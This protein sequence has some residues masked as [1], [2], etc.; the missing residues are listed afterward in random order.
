MK[1]VTGQK[2]KPPLSSLAKESRLFVC[3]TA[4][5]SKTSQCKSLKSC[6]DA[7]IQRKAAASNKICPVCKKEL[8]KKPNR[9][10]FQAVSVIYSTWWWEWIA[11]NSLDPSW[12]NNR[13]WGRQWT[14]GDREWDISRDGKYDG[15]C[16]RGWDGEWRNCGGRCDTK[17]LNSAKRSRLESVRGKTTRN[18]DNSLKFNK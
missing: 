15:D 11:N 13:Y 14:N 17:K 5:C 1:G 18:I 4:G 8:V 6:Y 10:A 3:P 7:N 9:Q 16:H 12:T 2:R